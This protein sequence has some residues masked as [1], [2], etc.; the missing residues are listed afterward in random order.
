MGC[1]ILYAWRSAMCRGA[2][3]GRRICRKLERAA[4]TAG[5]GS[6]A[7]FFG[8]ARE[9]S[10]PAA[11]GQGKLETRGRKELPRS[12]TK[13]ELFRDASQPVSDRMVGL[14]DGDGRIRLFASTQIRR[15]EKMGGTSAAEK[16]TNRRRYFGVNITDEKCQFVL[17]ASSFLPLCLA[18][19]RFF[20]SFVSQ[21]ISHT[22]FP[23]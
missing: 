19:D 15:G 8:Q 1:G 9:A 20:L 18:R 10:S 23:A 17:L 16:K 11:R 4:A 5:G 6:C 14:S 13:Q 12:L 7:V 21:G 3:L 2:I 22:G